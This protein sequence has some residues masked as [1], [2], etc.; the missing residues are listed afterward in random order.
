MTKKAVI[1]LLAVILL[2]GGI[3]VVSNM[4][5]RVKPLPE[6]EVGNSAGNLYN[7]GYFDEDEGVVYFSNPVDGYA[8]YSM[9]PDETGL[10]KLIDNNTGLINAA[11]KYIFYYQ[12]TMNASSLGFIGHNTGVYRA[13]KTGKNIVGLVRE[14]ASSVKLVGNFVYYEGFDNVEGLQIARVGID[15][16]NREILSNKVFNCAEYSNGRFYYSG[17]EEDHYLRTFDPNSKSVGTVFEGNIT[18]PVINGNTV[19]YLNNVDNYRLYAR[20]VTGEP[21]TER[22]LSDERVDC[23]NIASDGFIYYQTSD[24]DNPA[25][26]RMSM[27]GSQKQPVLTGNYTDINVTSQYVYFRLWDDRAT[28]LFHQKLGGGPAEQWTPYADK[29]K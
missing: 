27:D 28:V 3:V 8:L 14:P 6:D 7:G 23:F 17:V 16:K 18:Y 12:G 9:N 24:P 1:L 21:A 19:Y 29:G 22:P 4:V 2:V 20:A 26:M 25:L 13:D 5:M 15:K 10:K 11:G